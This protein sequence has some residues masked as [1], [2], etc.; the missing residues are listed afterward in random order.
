MAI[1]Y[2]VGIGPGDPELLTLKAKK[3]LEGVHVIA[4]PRGGRE[5]ESMALEVVKRAIDL[6][7]KEV[8]PLLFPMKRE[9]LESYWEEAR[10]EV[11]KRLES[12]RDVAFIT[13]GDPLFHSTFIHLLQG[14]EGV[15]VR[16]VPGVSFLQASTASALLPLASGQEGVAILP[17]TCGMERV[18]KALEGFDTVVLMKVYR[19]MREILCL[20]EELGLKERAVF[21]SRAGWEDEEVRRGND[22]PPEADYFSTLIVRKD[23]P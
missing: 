2:G 21:I 22:I 4:F 7:G 6:H 8:L 14:L 13:L 15:D 18:K 9:G 11:S 12:G 19:R 23:K 16:I 3:V 1:L 10:K 5:K 17:A 20:L